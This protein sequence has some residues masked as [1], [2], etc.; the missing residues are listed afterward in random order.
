MPIICYSTERASGVKVQEVIKRF[1]NI[2]VNVEGGVGVG[3]VR[4]KVDKETFES[5]SG[6]GTERGYEKA[7]HVIVRSLTH[8]FSERIDT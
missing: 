4:S 3:V 6:G 8:H 2:R 5:K 1:K 7:A